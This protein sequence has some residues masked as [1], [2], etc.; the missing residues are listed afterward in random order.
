[1]RETVEIPQ[2]PVRDLGAELHAAFG[3]PASCFGELPPQLRVV[4]V[5][6]SCT[7]HED[8]V[9]SRCS[10]NASYATNES[11]LCL[12]RRSVGMR[13]PPDVPDAPRSVGTRLELRR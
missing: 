6:L 11:D 9:T 1:V 10:T 5:D 13:L 4:S 3:D 7:V 2:A 12:R 8:G